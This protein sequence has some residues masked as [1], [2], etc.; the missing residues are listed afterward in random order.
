MGLVG[1]EEN[2]LSGFDDLLGLPVVEHLRS[3]QVDAAVAVIL[4]V[5]GEKGATKSPGLFA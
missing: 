1:L 5:P 4:V 3:E 2:L